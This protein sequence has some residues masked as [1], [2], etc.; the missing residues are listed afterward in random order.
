MQA[1]ILDFEKKRH[2]EEILAFDWTEMNAN[3]FVELE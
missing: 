3:A 2:E 1:E